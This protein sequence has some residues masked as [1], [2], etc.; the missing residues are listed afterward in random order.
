MRGLRAQLLQRIMRADYWFPSHRPA[1]REVKELLGAILV[2]D[3]AKR[4][5]IAQIQ[6]H[7]WCA[8]PVPRLLLQDRPGGLPSQ[9][10]DHHASPEAPLVRHTCAS[11]SLQNHPNRQPSQAADLNLNLKP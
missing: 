4:L 7:P 3:P 9:A 1:S 8:T 10:A 6:Q 2:V 5:T 11:Q